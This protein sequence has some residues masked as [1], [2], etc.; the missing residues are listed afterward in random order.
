MWSITGDIGA[1]EAGP[2]RDAVVQPTTIGSGAVQAK[3]LILPLEGRSQLIVRAGAPV[4]SHIETAPGGGNVSVGDLT[5]PVGAE[6]T[7]FAVG[8]DRK[9]NYAGELPA[10]W[11]AIG[12][13]GSVITAGLSSQ[14]TFTALAPGVGHIVAE[15]LVA[16][17]TCTGDITVSDGSQAST[18]GA[19]CGNGVA[20]AGEACDGADVR[21]ETCMARLAAMRDARASRRRIVLAER[22][23]R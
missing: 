16:L 1:V 14:A 8:Y 20:E 9:G 10:T 22:S 12:G 23:A 4:V 5:L 6:M 11:R 19:S 18:L 3:H 13:V 2:S 7:V 15:P 21:G 17:A